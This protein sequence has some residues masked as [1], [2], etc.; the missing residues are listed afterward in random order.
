MLFLNN[1]FDVEL[2]EKWILKIQFVSFLVV[3]ILLTFVNYNSNNLLLLFHPNT[4]THQHTFTH[5]ERERDRE[6]E[7]AGDI[8]I[9]PSEASL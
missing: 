5:S 1:E 7:S 8:R 6:R 3:S 9:I 4:S 2:N